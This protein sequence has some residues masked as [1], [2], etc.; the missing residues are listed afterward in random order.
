MTIGWETAITL[1]GAFGAASTAQFF[2]HQLTLKREDEKYKKEKYQ[3]LYSPLIFKIANY[4]KAEGESAK[5]KTKPYQSI[6]SQTSDD[7][8][9][10]YAGLIE[11]PDSDFIFKEIMSILEKNLKY[12]NT[13]FIQVYEQ[14]NSNV[15]VSNNPNLPNDFKESVSERRKDDALKHRMR[16]CEEFIS[17][18]M[19]ISEQL[20]TL[21]QELKNEFTNLLNGIR[22]FNLV[23][24]YNFRQT[25]YALLEFTGVSYKSQM[26]RI[27]E[28]KEKT[29]ETERNVDLAIETCRNNTGGK[30]GMYVYNSLKSFIEYTVEYLKRMHPTVKFINTLTNSMNA[31]LNAIEDIIEKNN[32]RSGKIKLVY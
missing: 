7:K 25:S 16:M 19:N 21:S 10:I 11:L 24:K 4:I 17:E 23:R 20:G 22:L 5:E 14:F 26:L 29:I 3:N 31:D 28:I 1:I 12:A 13:S 15:I 27:P 30:E 6:Q 32:K 9:R 18:Y 8:P 2:S